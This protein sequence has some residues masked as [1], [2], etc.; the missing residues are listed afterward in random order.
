MALTVSGDGTG[1]SDIFCLTLKQQVTNN[2]KT[3]NTGA[4]AERS[5]LRRSHDI[6]RKTKFKNWHERFV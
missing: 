3:K 2:T 4:E 6:T 5:A 1:G